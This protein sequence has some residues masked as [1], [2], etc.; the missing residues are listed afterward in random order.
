MGEIELSLSFEK[1]CFQGL[2]KVFP[3]ISD[4][5]SVRTKTRPKRSIGPT[6]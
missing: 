2:L 3:F 6:H 4:A 5:V 1:I